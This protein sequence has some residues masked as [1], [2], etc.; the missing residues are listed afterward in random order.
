MV[1]SLEDSIVPQEDP[2]LEDAGVKGWV[3]MDVMEKGKLEWT[4]GVPPPANKP[5]VDKNYSRFNLDGVV[6][7][8]GEAV[9]F[10]LGLHHH[11][12]EPEVWKT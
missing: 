2:A 5:E 9:P 11:G 4:S 10:H 1:S 7:P 12:D 3:H 6:I 8:R